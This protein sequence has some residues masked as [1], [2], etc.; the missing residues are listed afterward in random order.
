MFRLQ[1]PP[2]PFVARAHPKDACK[3]MSTFSRAQPLK[4]HLK[5]D[6][7][8]LREFEQEV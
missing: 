4:I 7:L 5:M 8:G 1:L 6:I 2:P 3:K